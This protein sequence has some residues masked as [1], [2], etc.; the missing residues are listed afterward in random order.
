MSGAARRA[1]HAKEHP[2]QAS[3]KG[4]NES[5]M[6]ARGAT[7]QPLGGAAKGEGGGEAG[8]RPDDRHLSVRRCFGKG[9]LNDSARQQ[10]ES[11]GGHCAWQRGQEKNWV[12]RQESDLES[13]S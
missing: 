6:R 12:S 3:G 8:I 7:R 13:P 10:S 9:A 2:P 1:G 5:L 11:W 4:N